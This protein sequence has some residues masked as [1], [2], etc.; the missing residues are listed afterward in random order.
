MTTAPTHEFYTTMLKYKN[1][2]DNKSA[3][4]YKIKYRNQLL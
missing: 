2:L 1:A 4:E 3:K